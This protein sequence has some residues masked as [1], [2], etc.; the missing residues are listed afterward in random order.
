MSARV[1][2][3]VGG[4][5]AGHIYPALS[6]AERH[7]QG[8]NAHIIYISEDTPLDYMILTSDHR[9]HKHVAYSFSAT[10]YRYGIQHAWRVL[11]CARAFSHSVSLLEQYRPDRVIATG[12]I[13]SVPVCYAAWALNIPVDVYELNAIPGRAAYHISY[14]ANTTYICFPQVR[15]YFP[16][17]ARVYDTRY[18]HTVNPAWKGARQQARDA[19]GIPY[20][21]TCLLVL[22]GSQGSYEVNKLMY[23]IIPWLDPERHVVLHQA[24]SC[25]LVSLQNRYHAYGIQA[26]VWSFV[27][28]MACLYAAADCCIA[29]A[30]AG[31]LH[32]L[33]YMSRPGY[34]IP[35]MHTAGSH[36]YHNA[37]AAAEM[38]PNLWVRR[39]QEAT[40]TDVYRFI[41]MIDTHRMNAYT[42]S[43]HADD[44]KSR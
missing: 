25:E 1:Y 31:T 16:K 32:E 23:H 15:R 27:H 18:P 11:T 39:P 28:D 35:L 8:T 3:Y 5:S 33:M 9:V 10:R 38:Y 43:M 42:T 20:H 2:C 4:K 14:I 12:G 24:G 34:V 37:C 41:A 17:T 30:G 6:L 29:R 36:Q 7:M 26:Y 21:V 44:L 40:V 13:V 22:G 19:Y